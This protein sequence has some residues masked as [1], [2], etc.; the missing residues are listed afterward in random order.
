MVAAVV[1]LLWSGLAYDDAAMRAACAASRPP[2]TRRRVQV[3]RFTGG[4]VGSK[5]FEPYHFEE[6]R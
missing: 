3:I 4:E 5:R 1:L 6:V 2:D